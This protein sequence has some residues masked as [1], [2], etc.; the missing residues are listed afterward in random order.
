MQ[1]FKEFYECDTKHRKLAWI[2]GQGTCVMRGNFKARPIEMVLSTMQA[3]I[4]H[5]LRVSLLLHPSLAASSLA[6]ALVLCL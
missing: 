6:H 3:S 1:L 4:H 2:Y 5:A